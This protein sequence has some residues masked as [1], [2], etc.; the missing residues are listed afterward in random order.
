M[1]L[2]APSA[3]PTTQTTA[4]QI[5]AAH[6]LVEFG[7]RHMM[8]TTVK[9]RF[10]GLSGTIVQVADDPSLSS[11]TAQIDATSIS[12]GDAQRDVHLRGADFFDV[13]QYPTISFKSTRIE[14]SGESFTVV[15]D[16]TIKGVTREVS[17][18]ATFNGRGTNPFG[19]V[20]AGFSAET[21][22]NRKDFGLNW[23][24]ALE[25]GGV[26]VG[27]NIKISI[28]LQAVEANG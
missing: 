3:T 13:E 27:D 6:S 22:I 16:L 10:T 9:G 8:F 20:V 28:E 11:V 21:K 1:T 4:W 23:T 7:V 5:D 15:G 17:L 12:T 2:T 14:G 24:V 18:D 26:L 19:R 25:T